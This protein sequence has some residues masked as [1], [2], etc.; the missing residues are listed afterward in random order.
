MEDDEIDEIYS[1]LDLNND[2]KVNYNDFLAAAM[3]KDTM[4]TDEKLR[5][6]FKVFD[7]D[8]SN[9]INAEDLIEA[10]NFSHTMEN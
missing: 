3:D 8:G 2:G 4:L 10:L 1:Q 5:S 9:S 7:S 6:A